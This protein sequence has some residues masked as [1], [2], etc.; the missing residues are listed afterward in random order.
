ML[1]PKVLGFDAHSEFRTSSEN[2]TQQVSIGCIVCNRQHAVV[3]IC[4]PQEIQFQ[5]ALL[6]FK[7]YS[8]IRIIYP[9]KKETFSSRMNDRLHLQGCSCVSLLGTKEHGHDYAS[10]FDFTQ[11]THGRNE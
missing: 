2:K 1:C 8:L 10:L 9:T 11:N 6:S 5:P 4:L 7:V 3:L